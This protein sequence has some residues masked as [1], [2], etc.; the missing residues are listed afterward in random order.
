MKLRG[1]TWFEPL[2]SMAVSKNSYY[3][4]SIITWSICKC[5]RNWKQ[6]PALPCPICQTDRL[7]L[8]CPAR[9]FQCPALPLPHVPKQTD[10][11]FFETWNEK[12]WVFFGIWVSGLVRTDGQTQ[13]NIVTLIYKT[14]G[15]PWPSATLVHV[16]ETFNFFIFIFMYFLFLLLFYIFFNLD[17][18]LKFGERRHTSFFFK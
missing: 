8:P 17:A 16:L 4:N 1:G 18:S 12:V 9:P 3:L 7:P 6:C 5:K 10:P 14:S 13:T 15:C 2:L 11:S